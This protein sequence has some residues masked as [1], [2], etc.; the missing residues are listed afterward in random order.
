MKHRSR[1]RRPDPTANSSHDHDGTDL[2][3]AARVARWLG[4]GRDPAAVDAD[5]V[6][7]LHPRIGNRATGS[8]IDRQLPGRPLPSS[9]R[10]DLEQTFGEPLDQVRVHTDGQ[11]A[12]RAA[13]EGAD[14]VT[15][16]Q[17]IAFAAGRYAPGTLQGDA[18]L[19]HEVAHTVQQRHAEQEHLAAFRADSGGEHAEEREADSAAAALV[20]GRLTRT[21]QRFRVA[22]QRASVARR[23]AIC[24]REPNLDEVQTAVDRAEEL[25]RLGA[26]ATADP[27]AQSRLRSAN[28]AIGQL[29]RH[30]DAVVN[31]Q[32]RA[33]DVFDVVDSIM[34][35]DRL[36]TDEG[37]WVDQE[38]AARE[39]GRL[40]AA[41]GRLM[42]ASG[43]PVLEQWGSF[44]AGAGDFFSNMYRQVNTDAIFEDRARR[45]GPEVERAIRF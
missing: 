24:R 25:T 33:E 2:G 20:R 10:T 31:A 41:S 6:E 18:L 30:V 12:S 19:A 43:I 5:D 22:R 26:M 45:Q 21:R 36:Q 17:D 4:A 27:D 23:R 40:F 1:E 39:F 16:G 42:E 11:A 9:T 38:A 28:R 3:R 15:A 32:H 29:K 13:Q 35:L 44:L 14:A 7:S 37:N 34:A 8:L